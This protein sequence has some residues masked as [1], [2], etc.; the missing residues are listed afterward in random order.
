MLNVFLYE[1]GTSYGD[2]SSKAAIEAAPIVLGKK[3]QI[4]IVSNLNSMNELLVGFDVGR[5]YYSYLKISYYEGIKL[6]RCGV[7]GWSIAN[8]YP[9]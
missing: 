6:Y 7:Q 5:P 4:I 1:S 9:Q 8:I 2:E 3:A